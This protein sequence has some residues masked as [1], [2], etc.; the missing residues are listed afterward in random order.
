MRLTELGPIWLSENMF[1]FR[2]PH[3]LKTWLT[4]KN[5]AIGAEE[6][7]DLAIAARLEPTG[8]RYGAVLSKP[9]LAWNWDENDFANMTVTPSIDA[10]AS[11]H[12]HGCITK[13]QIK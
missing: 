5:S 11:G 12:W 10:S 2:C 3:C 13:G 8:P 6:Q 4:C 7:R 9:S 1:A